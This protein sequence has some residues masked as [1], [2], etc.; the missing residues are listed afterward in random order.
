M[1]KTYFF[2]EITEGNTSVLVYKNKSVSKGPGFKEGVPF[3]NPTMQLNR[4]ISILVCQHLLDSSKRKTILLDGLAASGIRGVRFANELTGDFE[5]LI[6]DWDE[7]SYSL[8]K[9]NIE[10]HGFE[11]AKAC[12]MNLNVLL[13]SDK[14]DYIDVDP[15][16]SPV[17]FIDSAIR[18]IKNGGILA[19][20][21]TDTAALCGVYPKVCIRRY[22]AVPFHSVVMKEV[23]LRILLGFICRVAGVYD[24]GIHPLLCYS[25]DHYF[26]LYVK[27]YSSVPKAN[28]SMNNFKTIY[29]GENIGLQKA[30]NDIGPM[31]TG[32]IGDKKTINEILNIASGK[33]LGCKSQIYRLLDVLQEE[34]NGPIFFYTT[35]SIASNLKKSS[36]KLDLLFEKLKKQE[37]NVYR[38]HFSST[39][40]KTD[41][42]VAVIEKVFK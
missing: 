3:Y 24:K 18:S 14:F 19:C 29:S 5:V 33:K 21:A 10:K 26:R 39:G 7:K 32:E 6:N 35:E 16:G 11:N 27:V 34:V 12:N 36:P 20:S 40:F 42:P 25:T 41:A 15:F 31:W 8:I 1:N 38:T 13:S 4:D 22:G 23:G 2:E 17:C 37:Y 9:K 28:Q 30:K